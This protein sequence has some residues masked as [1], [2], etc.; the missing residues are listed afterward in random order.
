MSPLPTEAGQP[1]PP[2]SIKDIHQEQRRHSAWFSGDTD[3]L[4]RVYGA[5]SHAAIDS[6]EAAR[7]NRITGAIKNFFWGRRGVQDPLSD[8]LLQ[9]HVP[10]AGDIARTSADLL[11]ADPPTF[12]IP[13]AEDAAAQ[14]G[15]GDNANSKSEAKRAQ[16]RLEEL[17]EEGGVQNTLLEMAEFAAALGGAYLRP[18]WDIDVVGFPMLTAIPAD[19]AVPEFSYGVLTAVTFW[20]EL[21]TADTKVIRHLERYERGGM[22]FHGLYESN[23]HD[24][25]GTQ[26]PLSS[27]PDTRDLVDTRAGVPE[28][29]DFVIDVEGVD[30]LLVRYV[31]N[32]RPNRR[33]RTYQGRSD[34][35]GIETQ[36]D[37][38]DETYTSLMRDIRLGQARIL[39]ERQYLD[40][41]PGDPS[42]GA[43]FNTDRS[44]YTPV[45]MGPG[46][47]DS[48]PTDAIK[49]IEFN[50][51]VEEH[52]AAAK[53]L[54]DEAVSMA[55]YARQTFSPEHEG[56]ADNAS[57]LRMRER[58]SLSTMSKKERYVRTAL[59]DSLEILLKL[60]A[61]VFSNQTPVLRPNIGFSDAVGEGER[62]RAESIEVLRRAEIISIKTGVEMAHPDWSQEEILTEVEAIKAERGVDVPAI[63]PGDE[64]E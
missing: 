13:E 12:T 38:L 36:F 61:V 33:H 19:F 1:W 8:R 63:L 27:H 14:P 32:I 35:Q 49:P 17:V 28:R 60:D 44:I 37:A 55:G 62:E 25:L 39:I 6:V 42:S 56:R 24:A 53:A 47:P 31:P 18:V 46:A 22:I 50:I 64:G 26:V 40:S 21:E 2:R 54:R 7:P 51:R 4:K 34:F 59:A 5:G 30:D 58:K 16:D 3:R 11:F 9:L 43:Y 15:G 57:A 45:S 52:L 41:I 48:K 29:L 20:R 10:L 23:D